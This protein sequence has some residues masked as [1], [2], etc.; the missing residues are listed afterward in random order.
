MKKINLVRHQEIMKIYSFPYIADQQSKILI[1]GTMPSVRSLKLNQ[2]YGHGG[3]H[4]WKIMFSLFNLPFTKDY[5]ER[6]S[7]LIKNK[8]ALWDVLQHCQREGSA[9]SAIKDE[10][11]NDFASFFQQHPNIT[12]VF[13][14]GKKAKELFEKYNTLPNNITPFELP[15]TSSANT[16]FTLEKK[17]GLWQIVKESI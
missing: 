15:S 3:N 1:L 12:T 2:Y 9:D 14:N 5:N 4:F 16:W 8:I 6:T 13:F 11:S 10:Y 17:L 7:L